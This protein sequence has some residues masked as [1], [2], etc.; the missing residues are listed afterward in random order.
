MSET[1]DYK[2]QP[3]D[4]NQ[5]PR[6]LPSLGAVSWIAWFS[7]REMSRRRQPIWVRLS[8]F[9]IQHLCNV[10]SDKPARSDLTSSH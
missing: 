6:P 7:L 5:V 2:P 3:I 10:S 8:A 4:P 9:E 1:M